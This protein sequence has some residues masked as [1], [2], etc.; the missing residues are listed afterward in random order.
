MYHISMSKFQLIRKF[1]EQMQP[2]KQFYFLG[3]GGKMR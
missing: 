1:G 2:K 3:R